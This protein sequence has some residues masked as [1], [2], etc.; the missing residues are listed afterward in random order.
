MDAAFLGISA[1]V[2]GRTGSLLGRRR[3]R[4]AL[5]AVVGTVLVAF[6]IRLASQRR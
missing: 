2:I 1:L 3:V 5:E 4:R 6:G